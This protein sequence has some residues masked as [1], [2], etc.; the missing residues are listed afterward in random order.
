MMT[1]QIIQESLQNMFRIGRN[2][3]SLETCILRIYIATY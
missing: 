3:I 2:L 1:L